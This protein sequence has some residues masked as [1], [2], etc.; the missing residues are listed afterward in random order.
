[1]KKGHLSL[2]VDLPNLKLFVRHMDRIGN[3][4]S[5]SIVL[6]SFS[7]I[8]TGLIIGSSLGGRPVL[9]GVPAIE[10]GFVVAA[11]MFLWLLFAIFRSGRF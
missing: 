5:F 4:L 8:M 6:L 2:E 11:I 3:R 7:I 9:F 10:I 1:M